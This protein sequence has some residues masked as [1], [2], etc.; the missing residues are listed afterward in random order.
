MKE[1][2]AVFNTCHDLRQANV[3][4]R[5]FVDPFG[6]LE[7]ECEKITLKFKKVIGHKPDT[8]VQREPTGIKYKNVSKFCQ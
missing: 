7:V 2:T 5:T 3:I 4:T 8:T 6:P 1:H